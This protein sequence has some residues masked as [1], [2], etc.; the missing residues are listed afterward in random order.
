MI[1]E[2]GQMFSWRGE[3]FMFLDFTDERCDVMNCRSINGDEPC[4]AVNDEEIEWNDMDEGDEEL[5]YLMN[6][7]EEIWKE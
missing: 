6:E 2:K 1:P 3:E 4:F 7:L 5:K